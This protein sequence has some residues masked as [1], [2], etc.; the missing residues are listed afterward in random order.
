MTITTE[1]RQEI[2]A[3]LQAAIRDPECPVQYSPLLIAARKALA[4]LPQAP[5]DG[6]TPE[7]FASAIF[8]PGHSPANPCERGCYCDDHYASVLE[9]ISRPSFIAEHGEVK[10]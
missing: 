8:C 2:I 1:E 3:G 10:S 7:Q 6:P 5:S 9:L 4:A